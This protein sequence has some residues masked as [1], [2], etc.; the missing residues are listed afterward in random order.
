VFKTYQPEVDDIQIQYGITRD[1]NPGNFFDVYFGEI[2]YLAKDVFHA[3]GIKNKILYL[4]MPP[5][6]SHTGDHK[7]AKEI[8]Q[9]SIRER[10]DRLEIRSFSAE[11][12]TV[13]P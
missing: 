8:R 2:Y 1:I 10:A 4:I 9:Q 11:D 6:W 13:Q 5:G 7:L 3:P 12:R